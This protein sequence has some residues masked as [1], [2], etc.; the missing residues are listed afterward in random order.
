MACHMEQV[1]V[2][3]RG[4]GNVELPLILSPAFKLFVDYWY[5]LLESLQRHIFAEYLNQES[6][7]VITVETKVVFAQ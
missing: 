6:E 1:I 5:Y 7:C 2:E 3:R 4:T